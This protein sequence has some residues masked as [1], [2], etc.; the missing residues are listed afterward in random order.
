MVN[1]QKSSKPKT[2]NGAVGSQVNSSPP[3]NMTYGQHC[4]GM[5]STVVVKIVAES[6]F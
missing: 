1:Q 4:C 5:D 3:D 2:C 6:G